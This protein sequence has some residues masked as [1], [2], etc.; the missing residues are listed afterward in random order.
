MF[1]VVL[2]IPLVSVIF[3]NEALEKVL[4]TG[5]KLYKDYLSSIYS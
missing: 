2:A 3:P 5:I 4:L 1:E